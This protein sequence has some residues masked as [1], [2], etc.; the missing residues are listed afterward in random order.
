[1]IRR[2]DLRDGGAGAAPDYR[3]LVPRAD[4]DVEAALHV[5]R[6]ICDDVRDRGV[7]AIAEYS[8]RFDGVTQTDI[9]V[10][11]EALT[12]R[13]RTSTREIR[14]GLEESIRRL[15]ITCEAELG[16]DIVTDL[17]PGRASPSG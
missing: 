15:R 13:W 8:E 14:A 5:V 2:I 6:P 12:G 3:T 11:R 17:G 4:F 9:T 7:E 10:P 16:S 1:M